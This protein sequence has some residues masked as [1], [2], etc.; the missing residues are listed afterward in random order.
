LNWIFKITLVLNG[1]P[2]RKAK[3]EFDLDQGISKKQQADVNF[4]FHLENNLFY[5]S[6]L[7]LNRKKKIE[8]WNDIP[9]ITKKDFQINIDDIITKGLSKSKLH[10]HNT[11]GSTG[12][13][14]YFAKDKFCHAMNWAEIDYHLLKHSINIGESKQVRFY[15]IPLSG[16]KHYKER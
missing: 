2:I 15:G 13:P 14:F 12:T 7:K 10:V 1:F 16:I 11:S 8:N 9:V 5:Q 6:F 3:K 4:R